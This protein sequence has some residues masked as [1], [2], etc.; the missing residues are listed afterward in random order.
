MHSEYRSLDFPK[1]LDGSR[2]YLKSH[3]SIE[4]DMEMLIKRTRIGR[5][6]VYI[7]WSENNIKTIW[8]ICDEFLNYSLLQNKTYVQISDCI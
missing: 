7:N 8:I 6:L 2:N 3:L 4:E 5:Y 1:Y